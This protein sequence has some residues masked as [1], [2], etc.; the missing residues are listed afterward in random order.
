MAKKSSIQIENYNTPGEREIKPRC[1]AVEIAGEP[2]AFRCMARDALVYSLEQL[3]TWA[4]RVDY[5]LF[6]IRWA[7]QQ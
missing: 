5:Q 3:V 2:G 6:V 7:A 4:R 1:Y